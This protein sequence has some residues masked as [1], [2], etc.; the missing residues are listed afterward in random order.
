MFYLRRMNV[1]CCMFLLVLSQVN[2]QDKDELFSFCT[3]IMARN[4][5]SFTAGCQWNDPCLQQVSRKEAIIFSIQD[6]RIVHDRTSL[7][8]FES[9]DYSPYEGCRT[10]RKSAYITRKVEHKWK[11]MEHVI[12]DIRLKIQ[13]PTKIQLF[14]GSDNNRLEDYV[15]VLVS[16]Q[17]MRELMIN[18]LQMNG[19]LS[20]CF[21]LTIK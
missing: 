6:K 8:F 2:Y 12:N 20:G 16:P 13:Y 15:S 17:E 21:H 19:L 4:H 18:H 11:E 1:L 3:K 5:I 7:R 9:D 10:G 14:M